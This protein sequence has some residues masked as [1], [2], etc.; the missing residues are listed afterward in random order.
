MILAQANEIGLDVKFYGADGISDIV[1]YV[2]EKKLPTNVV[3]TDHFL[4]RRPELETAKKC[5]APSRLSAARQG[6]HHLLLRHRL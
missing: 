2:A 1:D 3:Y 6:A 4:H 5:S